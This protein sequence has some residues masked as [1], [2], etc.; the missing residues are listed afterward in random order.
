MAP[1]RLPT[2]LIHQSERAGPR[3]AARPCRDCKPPLA[4]APRGS[5]RR[6]WLLT[7][8]RTPRVG[9]GA[10][11]GGGVRCRRRRGDERVADSAAVG[12]ACCSLPSRPRPPSSTTCA[13]SAPT[14]CRR[15]RRTSPSST[16]RASRWIAYVG[17]HGGRRLNPLT[18]QMEQNGTSIV[19]V[20]DPAA[21]RATCTTSPARR[22][23]RR[24]A[25]RR[26]CAS[27]TARR[28]RAGRAGRPISCAR[29]AIVA[30]EIWDVTDPGEAR[31]GSPRCWTGSR[32][33]TRTGGSATPASPTWSPTARPP[34]WRTNRMTKIYDLS[35]PAQPRFIRDF[36]LPGQEPG[37]DRHRARRACTGRSPTG[38]AS[39]SPT[40]PAPRACCRS[41]TARSCSRAIR[42]RADRFAPTVREPAL[43]ADRPARHVAG[44]G[45]A[46]QLPGAGRARADWAPGSAGAHARLRAARL[47][48]A[49]QRVPGGPPAHLH[50]GRHR[51]SR[52]RSPS[53]PS[54]CPIPPGDFC[55]RG[56]R[57][58]PHSS[59]ESF[60]PD[61]LRPPRLHRLLQRGR[62]RGGHPR[63]VPP[64]GGGL[65][66][67]GRHR[68]DRQALRG[69]GR[70]RRA[71]RSR[72]RPTTWR[73]TTAG[74]IYLAD[75]ADTGLHIVELTGPARAIANL[76]RMTP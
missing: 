9:L 65:L 53:P 25:A 70:R 12:P 15:A 47:G 58:G 11:T 74:Y 6:D 75:R 76:P 69:G 50:G 10:A 64:G 29:S 22:A 63:S 59:H 45:R 8:A 31:V 72:S 67:P 52:A 40:A 37:S 28:C 26:W 61:L 7:A 14:I 24:R 21:A 66:H 38:T 42:R 4:A 23:R 56:G 30:H 55:R 49:P 43:P 34:G 5:G 51:P 73:W 46:H 16:S 62:A 18:G 68:P 39:T 19:D 27:A 33:R 36:G 32:A 44:L 57:F 20:T 41:W 54:R 48:V 3:G 1:S 2:V 35:D 71:A 60:T 17:H 13:W